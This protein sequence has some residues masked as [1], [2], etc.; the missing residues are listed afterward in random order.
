MNAHL[1][2]VR[3]IWD[4]APHNAFTDLVRFQ[5]RWFCSFREAQDHMSSDGRIRLIAA[6]EANASGALQ[7]E[8]AALL[9][10]PDALLPDLRDPKIGITPDHRLMLMGAGT[11]RDEA[12]GRRNYVWF[13][14]DGFTWSEPAAIGGKD[15]WIWS[16][17]WAG[18]VLYG[19][20]YDYRDGVGSVTLYHG[21]DAMHFESPTVLHTDLQY[22]NET[23]LLIEGSDGLALIRREYAP[24]QTQSPPYNNGTA[25]LARAQAPFKEWMARD[26][27]VYVGGP[28]LLRLP[29]GRVI[30]AGRKI[31][32]G[33]YTALW[34]LD[35]ENATLQEICVLPSANDCSYPGLA[36]HEDKLWV[37]Y[38]SEHEGKAA[39]YFAELTIS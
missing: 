3:K 8:N 11:S 30:A 5:D 4:E 12:A 23:A 29:D 39:I 18:D 20:G 7:W 22:P 34:E 25:A 16:F 33:H 28:A 31:T 10:S 35:V 36:W 2:Q 19:A 24:G 1:H 26:L 27:G 17:A 15:D 9:A 37:S 21:P 14:E 32:S 38:Y 13:S 6:T